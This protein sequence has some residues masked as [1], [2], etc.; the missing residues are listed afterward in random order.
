MTIV[1]PYIFSIW[2]VFFASA[3]FQAPLWRA[4]F[5]KY[6]ACILILNGIHQSSNGSKVLI[7]YFLQKSLL[8]LIET[9]SWKMNLSFNLIYER[10][11]NRTYL[12][13]YFLKFL[14]NL[15]LQSLYKIWS[16]RHKSSRGL[17]GKEGVGYGGWTGGPT[18]ITER[19]LGGLWCRTYVSYPC[20]S[21]VL[22]FQRT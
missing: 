8:F 3:I 1:R 19:D 17:M 9:T 15:H 7:T 6:A 21:H 16:S 18:E 4:R 20:R 11:I 12:A 13:G 10:E 22:G 14:G 5:M 2:K